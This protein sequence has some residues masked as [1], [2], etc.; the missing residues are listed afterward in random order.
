M[1]QYTEYLE[2]YGKKAKA[3]SMQL[4]TLPVKIKNDILETAAD[5]LISRSEEIIA[6][7]NIDLEN[8]KANGK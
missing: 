8:A 7:N 2:N 5:M 4:A 6:A 1:S 3:A